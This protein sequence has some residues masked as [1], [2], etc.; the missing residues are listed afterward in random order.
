MRKLATSF[1]SPRH[2]LIVMTLCI[3]VCPLFPEGFIVAPEHAISSERYLKRPSFTYEDCRLGTTLVADCVLNEAS[4][5]EFL[6]THPHPHI[7]SYFGC[8][9]TTDGRITHLCLK[10]YQSSLSEYAESGLSEAQV[11]RLVGGIKG[12]IEHLHSL[13][14]A[15]NDITPD[16]ICVDSTGEAVIVDFDSCIP[17]GERLTKGA[18]SNSRTSRDAPVS[19]KENDS[20]GLDD[21]ASSLSAPNQ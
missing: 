8:R 11:V 15:H 5:L 9:V 7:G 10:R 12:G 13:G 14:L 2:L 17:F 20:R 3:G 1:A 4:V 16:N 6:E 19:S 18:G 21:I